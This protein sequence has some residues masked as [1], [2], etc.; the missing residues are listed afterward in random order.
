MFSRDGGETWTSAQPARFFPSPCSPM[1]VKRAPDGALYAV[2]NPVPYTL[3]G[4]APGLRQT[5]SPLA[6]AVSRDEGRSWSVPR[7]LDALEPGIPGVVEYPAVYCLPDALLVCCD[8][9]VGDRL[10]M[11]IRRVEYTELA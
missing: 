7:I 9:S 4:D 11:V 5:R 8:M 1:V 2:W 3:S 10:D 6:A